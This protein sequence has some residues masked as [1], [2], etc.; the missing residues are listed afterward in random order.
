LRMHLPERFC[1]L[2]L[3]DVG[4][5]LELDALPGSRSSS[6]TKPADVIRPRCT[7]RHDEL[8]K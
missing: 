1:F 6:F 7:A 5:T 4:H 3:L 2:F 8:L